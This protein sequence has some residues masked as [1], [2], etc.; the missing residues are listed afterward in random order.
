MTENTDEKI[1]IYMLDA[2]LMFGIVWISNISHI[3][4]KGTNKNGGKLNKDRHGPNRS[5]NPS[6]WC[7]VWHIVDSNLV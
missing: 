1:Y 5:G 4:N 3:L 6:F 2:A 7:V